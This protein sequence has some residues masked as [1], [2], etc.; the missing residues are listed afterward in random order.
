MNIRNI[1]LF[2]FLIPLGIWAQVNPQQGNEIPKILIVYFSHSGNTRTVAKM[3]QEQTGGDLFEIITEKPYPK[4]YD[5]V[6]AIAKK[7]QEATA[8]PA[9]KNHLR[10]VK[11]YDVIFIGFP[12]WWGTFPMAVASFL[13]END[14]TGKILIPFCTHE[15]SYMGSS[16][17]DLG[18]QEPKAK[19]LDG[20]PIRGRSVKGAQD[21]VAR[22]IKRL[23]V[24][25]K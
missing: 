11:N 5:A 20:L 6:V 12:N 8:R 24:I 16:E 22:W 13:D 10:N 19:I 2:L 21:E 18:K 17:S 9:L 15:G 7:E 25:K 3:I 23:D 14:L 1:L 4:D